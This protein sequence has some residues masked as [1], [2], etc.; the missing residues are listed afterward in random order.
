MNSAKKIIELFG[1]QSALAE[2]INKRQ[3]TVGYWAKKGTIPAAWHGKLLHLAREQGL[4]LLPGDFVSMPDNTDKD[5]L[6]AESE[7]PT[8]T[9]WGELTIGD[10]GIPCYVL[11]NGDRV[12]SLK[13]VVVGLIGTEGGQLAEYLKVKALQPHLPRDLLPAENGEVSAFFKF[14]TGGEGFTKYAIGIRVERF[15][16]LLCAYSSALLDHHLSASDPTKIALTDRQLQIAT[17]AVRFLQASS[18]VGLVALVDEAT[19]Y[20][21]ERAADA[22][23]L[24][25]KLFLEDDM[26]KWEK[27]FPDQLWLEFGRLTK[28]KGPVHLRPKYWGKLVMELIYSYLDA[29]VAKWLKEN[30]P[31]PIKGQSYHQWLSSQY[32]LKKLTEHTWMVIG[33]ASACSTMGEL[34]QRMG[35]KYGRRPVQMTIFVDDN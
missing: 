16:D 8:A 27:T 34:R 30:A 17:T 35:E 26:R 9:H 1:G 13:G 2:L 6:P 5:L 15:N 20:Q 19:G 28:W 32:G 14:D 3:S 23:Q 10:K 29:D 18:G 24:K 22:L 7:Y 12:F 21:Y 33:L 31:K 25:L 4:E 11:S